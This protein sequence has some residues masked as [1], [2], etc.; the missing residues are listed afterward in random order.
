MKLRI[1]KMIKEYQVKIDL[2]D[3]VLLQI[4]EQYRVARKNNDQDTMDNLR[5]DRQ[6][7]STQRQSY[8]QVI[9]DLESI[10]MMTDDE[11]WDLEGILI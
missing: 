3:P 1:E 5:E 11:V 4:K 9:A 10:L 7:Y 8:V 6:K 2:I